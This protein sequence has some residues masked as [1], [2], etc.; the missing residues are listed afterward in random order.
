MN[1]KKLIKE[2]IVKELARI[3]HLFK[4]STL[5]DKELESMI[6][7]EIKNKSVTKNIIRFFKDNN[8]KASLRQDIVDYYGYPDTATIGSTFKAL[9]TAGV[10]VSQG[11]SQPKIIKPA[12]SSVLGRSITPVEDRDDKGKIA[13]IVYK[14]KN[15]QEPN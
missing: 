15:D 9:Q 14:L 10:V 5:D 3:A 11:L 8:N 7:D 2:E 6:P 12:P 4:L 1:Y 13:Y